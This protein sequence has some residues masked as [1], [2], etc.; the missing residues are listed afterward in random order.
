LRKDDGLLM[1]GR[2]CMSVV[3]QFD[4]LLQYALA[5]PIYHSSASQVKLFFREIIS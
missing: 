3:E 4:Q 1:D 5:K 2:A